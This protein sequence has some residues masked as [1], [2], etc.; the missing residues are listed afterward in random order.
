MAK[1]K[2]PC[3][4]HSHIDCHNFPWCTFSLAIMNNR[5]TCS[6][7]GVSLV[8]FDCRTCITLSICELT[9]EEN[10]RLIVKKGE[11]MGHSSLLWFS[12]DALVPYSKWKGILALSAISDTS[13][14]IME[15]K[16]P[17][18]L[19]RI[20]CD[21]KRVLGELNTMYLS[22]QGNRVVGSALKNWHKSPMRKPKTGCLDT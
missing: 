7:T 2:Q 22:S 5:P 13:G 6:I 8:I 16:K 10:W 11:A 3:V 9:K 12:N 17:R 21:N 1:I 15:T 19:E 18:S 14:F 20:I 4:I